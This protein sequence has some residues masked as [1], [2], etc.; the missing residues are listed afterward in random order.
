MIWSYIYFLIA[1]KTVFVSHFLILG[2]L[3][4]MEVGR[5]VLITSSYT[6]MF[7]S[8]QHLSLFSRYESTR[9]WQETHWITYLNIFGEIKTI[10]KKWYSSSKHSC[11]VQLTHLLVMYFVSSLGHSS[12]Y[13][14]KAIS[15]LKKLT[16]WEKRWISTLWQVLW[17]R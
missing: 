13:R 4:R 11:T 8:F 1:S 16:L 17:K 5:K 9:N 2:L 14:E 12:G 6:R 15:D 10:F 7:V 3:L